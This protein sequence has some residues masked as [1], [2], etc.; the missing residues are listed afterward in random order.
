VSI[1]ARLPLWVSAGSSRDALEWDPWRKRW[2]VFCRVPATGGGA[3]RAVAAL[4]ADWLGLPHLAVRWLVAGTSRAKV[5]R[6]DGITDVEA[7]RRLR[8]HATVQEG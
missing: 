1:V 4:V 6:V 8:S 5:L 3:N 7:E 2:V